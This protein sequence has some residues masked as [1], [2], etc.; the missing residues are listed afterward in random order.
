MMKDVQV[1]DVKPYFQEREA[2]VNKGNFGKVGMLGGS[3]N[4]VGALKLATFSYSALRSG[5]GIARVIIPEDLAIFL[6]PHIM[7]PTMFF[8]HNL[9]ELRIAIRDLKS[10]VIGIGWG[11]DGSHLEILQ[12]VFRTFSGSIVLDADG[13]NILAGHLDILPKNQVVLTPHLK[14]FSRLT[15]ISVEK[16]TKNKIE[17]AK[18]FA[19]KYQVI[20][21]LKGHTTIVSDGEDVYLCICGSPGM[22]TSGSGD[23]LSGILTGLLGYLEYN[24]LSVCAG[25]LLNGLAGEIA[26]NKNT[27]ISM[28]ASDTIKCI[29]DAIKK[30]REVECK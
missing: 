24:L 27:D 19:K 15:K 25:V 4:Y 21:L 26:E 13:L 8:Y 18:E 1:E 3:K 14:E 22:A 11:I 28:I 29:P 12:E 5:C 6:T 7:E 16:L 23:V 10:L 20:L 30:I 9:T 17:I 2:E